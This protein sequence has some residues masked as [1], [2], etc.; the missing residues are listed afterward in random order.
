MKG[1]K[2]CSRLSFANAEDEPDDAVMEAVCM[3]TLIH[4]LSKRLHI[5]IGK[6]LGIDEML[7]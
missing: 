6:A 1:R 2:L 3:H 7:R 4:C 5:R